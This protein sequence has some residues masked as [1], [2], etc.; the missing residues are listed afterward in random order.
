[1]DEITQ[2]H[3]FEPFFTTK[4]GGKGTGLGLSSVY[5]GIQ[6]NCGRIYVESQIGK[7]TEFTIWMPSHSPVNSTEVHPA[8]VKGIDQGT[9]TILL[10]EDEVALRRMLREA[11]RK[12]GYRV[13]EAG[14]GAEALEQWD[15][16]AGRVDLVVTD[17]VMPI[18]NGLRLAQ[19]LKKESPDL[20]LMFMS[21][22]SED[23]IVKQ[24]VRDRDV[25][26]LVKP[27]LPEVLVRQ[28]RQVLDRKSVGLIE[29]L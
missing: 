24:G 15:K 20:L 26:V 1:M 2:Q 4:E 27:F 9:E 28:V 29:S 12:A 16:T 19:E 13:W 21:G 23:V 25:I 8:E 14:N 10:V 7:G 3:L 6:Q 5:G 11:L 22:H 17:I 18:M